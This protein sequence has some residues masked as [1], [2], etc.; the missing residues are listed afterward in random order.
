M[1]SRTIHN[2]VTNGES[3]NVEFKLAASSAKDLAREIAA[4]T[5]TCGGTIIIG[6]DD[7]G[8]IFGV[9]NFKVTEEVITK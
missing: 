2:L 8:E 4:F 9:N 7:K 5:N 3:Q 6:V 1:N